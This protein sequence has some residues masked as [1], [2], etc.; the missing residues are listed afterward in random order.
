MR[1]NTH[2]EFFHGRGHYLF[3]QVKNLCSV[4]QIQLTYF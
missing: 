3:L 4:T 1:T 2:K